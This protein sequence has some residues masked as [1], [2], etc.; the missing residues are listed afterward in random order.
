MKL[1][2]S[3]LLLIV[4]FPAFAQSVSIATPVILDTDIGPDYDDVGAVAVLHALADKGEAIPLAIIASNKNELV[5]PTINVLNI[6]FGRPHLPIGAPKGHAPN[7]GA[8]Q[9][10]PEMLL[11]KYAH[12]IKSTDDVPDAVSIY[13]KILAQQADHSVTIA[14][15]GFLTNLSDLL[16]SKPDQFS[17]LPGRELI[18]QKVS[19]LVSMAGGFPKGREYNLLTDSSASANVFANWPTTI[20]FSGF[21]IGKEIKTGLG[22][23][24]D[25]SLESPVKDVFALCIP[26]TK[27]DSAGRMSWDETTVLVAIRGA[28]PYFG[29]QRGHII[30]NGGDNSWKANTHGS[31][32]YLTKAMPYEEIAAILESYMKHTGRK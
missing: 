16:N 2:V 5:A 10:W 30:I 4:F 9:K 13:R 11:A 12:T 29:L 8:W 28:K 7:I 22:L 3:L 21:E 24:N 31:Q 6:Y 15:I 32:Y 20:I 27:E 23:V 25:Q 26:K 17:P 18:K 1:F 19:K 14:T